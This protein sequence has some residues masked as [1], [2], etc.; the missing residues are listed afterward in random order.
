MSVPVILECISE[1]FN[2]LTFTEVV[3]VFLSVKISVATFIVAQSI[4]YL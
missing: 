3:L 2:L 1:N 4:K